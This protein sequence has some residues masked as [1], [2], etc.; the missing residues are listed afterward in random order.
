MAPL[1]ILPASRTSTDAAH[2]YEHEH[3]HE[4]A[5]T[6]ESRHAT[7]AGCVL[8]VRCATCGTRRVDL[9]GGLDTPPTPLSR[10]VGE[11]PV[12]PVR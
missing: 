8:Y 5:W 6:T 1:H 4:H 11:R 10:A 2:E 3:E 7:S 12:R 9:Q